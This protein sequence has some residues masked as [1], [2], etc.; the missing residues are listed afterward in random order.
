MRSKVMRRLII[1]IGRL[2]QGFTNGITFVVD[3][4]EYK[5]PLSSFALKEH[6][7]D[8][9]VILIFP[10]SL[11]LNKR[12]IDNQ[13]SLNNCLK[14]SIANIIGNPSQY[15]KNPLCFFKNKQPHGKDAYDCLIIHS[16]G[17]YEGVKFE[18]YFDDVV[19]EI[20]AYLV[21]NYL[22]NEKI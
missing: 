17:E 12:L 18:D 10:V 11:P 3:S 16:I 13:S 15:F 7:K 19:L 21:K 20:F 5:K 4:N 6:F 22:E 14:S 9:S 1:Q 2:D 8:T